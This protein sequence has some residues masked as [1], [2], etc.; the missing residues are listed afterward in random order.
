M[1]VADQ[2]SPR[3]SLFLDQT[4]FVLRPP[5]SPRPPPDTLFRHWIVWREIESGEKKK[6]EERKR[7]KQEIGIITP[8]L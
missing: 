3:L 4:E 5:L 7:E 2:G 8:F 1:A 6:A